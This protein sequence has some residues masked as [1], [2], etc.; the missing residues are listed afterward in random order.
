L[1]VTR[2][3]HHARNI[4]DVSVSTSSTNPLRGLVAVGTPDS[5]ITFEMNEEIAHRLCTV[6]ERFLTQK[7]R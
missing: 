3:I 1:A 7:Q 4:T 5:T 6:L 2:E